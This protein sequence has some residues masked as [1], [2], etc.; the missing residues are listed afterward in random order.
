MSRMVSRW[1][2]LAISLGLPIDKVQQYE[3]KPH[4]ELKALQ[5]WRNG[6]SS[7]IFPPT[8]GFLLEQVEATSGKAM[9]RAIRR[10]AEMNPT[11]SQSSPGSISQGEI[12]SL[13]TCMYNMY[14][15]TVC[16]GA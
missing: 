1:E 9:A 13:N 3:S 7:S 8:W 4:G 6:N 5:Y 14:V 16:E 2:S 12:C 15:D 10:E 11:F